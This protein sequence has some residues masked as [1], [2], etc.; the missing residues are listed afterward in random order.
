MKYL[1]WDVYKNQLLRK[2]HSPSSSLR[3]IKISGDGSK[4]FWMARRCIAVV[5][6]ETGQELGRVGLRSG[7][8]HNLFVCGSKVWVNDLHYRG[9]DF[10]GPGVLN[11]VEC[12]GEQRLNLV[13]WE[14]ADPCDRKPW[15]I[16]DTVTKRAVFFLPE[17][18]LEYSRETSWDGRYLLNCSYTGEDIVILDFD[19][20][21]PRSGS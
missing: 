11:F 5:S 17:K 13:G 8:G 2:F 16:E 15:R 9:W 18:C 14:A 1:I 4:I 10:G 3:D 20:V 7:A 12:T 19:P 21:C 6:M